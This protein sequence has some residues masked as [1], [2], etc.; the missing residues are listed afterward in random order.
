MNNYNKAKD[1]TFLDTKQIGDFIAQDKAQYGAAVKNYNGVLDQYR[2]MARRYKM[3]PTIIQDF[4]VAGAAPTPR[5]NRIAAADFNARTAPGVG[6][7]GASGE[8]NLD[9]FKGLN[10]AQT[11]DVTDLLDKYK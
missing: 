8:W 4:R 9:A 11:H 6:L 3:D 5:D 2:D 1:G 10:P 7:A